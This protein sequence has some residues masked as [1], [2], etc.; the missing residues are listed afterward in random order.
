M[1]YGFALGSRA[2][3]L[4]GYVTLEFSQEFRRHIVDDCG[5]VLDDADIGAVFKQL[6]EHEMRFGMPAQQ[7]VEAY[8]NNRSRRRSVKRLSPQHRYA[9]VARRTA[10]N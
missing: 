10:A 4:L 2:G 8:R 6:R 9:N 5:V 7:I 1:E 3:G